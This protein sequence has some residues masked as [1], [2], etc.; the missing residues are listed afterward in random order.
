MGIKANIFLM[1]GNLGNDYSVVE[2][3]KHFWS[4]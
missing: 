1:V 4:D 3:V 2:K